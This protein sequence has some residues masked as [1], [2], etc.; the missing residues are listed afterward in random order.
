MHAV[1]PNS[2]SCVREHNYITQRICSLRNRPLALRHKLRIPELRLHDAVAYYRSSSAS[3]ISTVNFGSTHYFPVCTSSLSY[4]EKN[5][6]TFDEVKSRKTNRHIRQ[7]AIERPRH[8]R[9]LA[10][11]GGYEHSVS[12]RSTSTP[13][14]F[15]SPNFFFRSASGEDM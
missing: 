2:D 15:P 4:P 14:E 5:E 12:M 10:H 11:D 3:H 6:A 7:M 9:L 1:H 8:R 13:T